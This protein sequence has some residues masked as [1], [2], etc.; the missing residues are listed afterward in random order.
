MNH[1]ESKIRQPLKIWKLTTKR[2][3]SDAHP[4]PSKNYNEYTESN[5]DDG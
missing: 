2:I 5:M 1:Y 3:V 4:C